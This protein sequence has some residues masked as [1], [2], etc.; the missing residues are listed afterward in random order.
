[1]DQD[2]A[3]QQYLQEVQDLFEDFDVRGTASKAPT[4][5]GGSALR[6]KGEELTLDNG[7]MIGAVSMPKVDM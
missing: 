4:S 2:V 5:T 6:A 3:K 1:M 7:G